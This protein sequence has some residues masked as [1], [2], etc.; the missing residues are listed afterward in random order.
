M[1]RAAIADGTD[2]GL[3][4]KGIMDRGELVSDEIIVGM[5][6]SRIDDDDSPMASF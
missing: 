6:A 3:R 2:L 4:A 1:L 5:I